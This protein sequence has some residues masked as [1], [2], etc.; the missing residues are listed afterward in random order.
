MPARTAVKSITALPGDLSNSEHLC[1]AGSDII[2]R[3]AGLGVTLLEKCVTWDE[4]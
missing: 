3:C 2:R 1:Q 4:L